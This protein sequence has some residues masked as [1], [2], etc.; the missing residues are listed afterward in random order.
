MEKTSR[1][2]PQLS[3]SAKG[4]PI[5]LVSAAIL[6]TSAIFVRHLTTAYGLPPVILSFWRAIFTTSVLAVILFAGGKGM[7]KVPRRQLAFLAVF[8]L[9][10][11]LFNSFWTVSV[12]LNGAAAA[13]V[14][15][16]CSGA[17]TVLLGWL[18]LKESLALSK[19]V[20]VILC[21][22]GCVLVAGAYSPAAWELNTTGI[23]CGIGSGLLYAIYT[24]MGRSAARRGINPWTTLCY[25]FG[26]GAPWL[27]GIDLAGAGSLPGT[28]PGFANL[29]WPGMTGFAWLLLFIL[30]ALPTLTGYGLYNV[31]LTLLPSS[32]VNLVVTTEPV[33]TAVW[34]YLLLG[35]RFSLVQLSG[36]L[37]ILAG[38][39]ILRV[40]GRE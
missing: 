30:A 21:L 10:L 28:A 25:V 38:V 31:S 29:V 32:V 17:F 18:L 19:V 13:T 11:A 26:F 12:S 27:L 35:E 7:L 6:S 9:L 15:A 5:A 40:T 33:F 37:L 8:G 2:H 39:V 20:V 22:A 14:L 1:F 23:I 3:T 4:Y 34:A 36:G 24:L 16:Y